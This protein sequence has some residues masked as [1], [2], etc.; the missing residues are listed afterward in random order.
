LKKNYIIYSSEYPRGYY[1]D[2]ICRYEKVLEILEDPNNSTLKEHYEIV[3][4]TKID[5]EDCEIVHEKLY[6]K[7]LMR[8]SSENARFKEAL[9]WDLL[10]TSGTIL[11]CEIA[12]RNKIT[13]HL[14]GGFHHAFR[15][16][17]GGFDYINDIAVAIEWIRKTHK[18]ER[19]MIIDLDVHH[20]NGT[21]SIFYDDPGVLQISFHGWGIF[22][23]SGDVSEI[24]EGKGKGYKINLPFLKNTSDET[25][26]YAM[27]K[28]IPPLIKSY[29]P[30]LIVYQ[31]GVDVLI[32]DPLGNLKLTLDGV[33]RRDQKIKEFTVGYPLAII[34]GGGYNN[35]YSPKANINT[36]ACFA[37]LPLVF[38]YPKEVSEPKRCRRWTE[39]KINELKEILKEYW[40][41][42]ED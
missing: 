37:G 35:D 4:P 20:A 13:Y 30:Q 22:P 26:L 21:Q 29:K 36:L 16:K 28:V 3:E 2:F 12:L 10:A 8:K 33:Y 34:R 5:L 1:K 14:G 39:K 32:K 15:N 19:I 18:L 7:N 31:A 11:A 41:W 25:Y 24:G 27:D 9:M 42:Y 38:S 23:G 6:L 40:E 17:E